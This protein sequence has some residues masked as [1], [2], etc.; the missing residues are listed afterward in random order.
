M[1]SGTDWQALRQMTSH[2]KVYHEGDMRFYV[3]RIPKL[4]VIP[5]LQCR[6]FRL[7]SGNKTALTIDRI[8]HFA[9]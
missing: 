2:D 7:Y 9:P 6:L 8:K 4:L 3:V 5:D 1:T